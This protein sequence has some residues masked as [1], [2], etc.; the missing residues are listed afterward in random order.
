MTGMGRKLPF[1]SPQTVHPR[2]EIQSLQ[3][4]YWSRRLVAIASTEARFGFV[5]HLADD[6][7]SLAPATVPPHE[8][9]MLIVK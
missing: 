3:F 5:G 2:L 8:L 9:T 6:F 1:G 4:I 7:G